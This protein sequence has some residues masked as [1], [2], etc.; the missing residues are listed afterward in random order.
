MTDAVGAQFET[1]ETSA[2]GSEAAVEALAGT[3]EAVGGQ[4]DTL[5]RGTATPIGLVATPT[6]ILTNGGEST[7]HPVLAATESSAPHVEAAVPAV[8]DRRATS[9]RRQVRSQR[10]RTR[11]SAP[12]RPPPSRCSGASPPLR[13]PSPRRRPRWRFL[14]VTSRHSRRRPSPS[15]LRRRQELVAAVVDVPGDP[16]F[17]DSA[18]TRLRG[19]GHWLRGHCSRPSG[20]RDADVRV[21]R[22]VSC[23]GRRHR[24]DGC[25]RRGRDRARSGRDLRPWPSCVLTG[26]LDAVHERAA[27]AVRRHCG[28]PALDRCGGLRRRQ[29]GRRRNPLDPRAVSSAS[30]ELA[31]RTVRRRLQGRGERI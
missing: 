3:V 8:T 21:R 13:I 19:A 7:L 26:R 1:A 6:E 24:H 4:I 28:N 10:R 22:V 2:A 17:G 31:C 23:A 14:R 25:E 27:A 18:G 5:T 15:H 11:R 9:C 12:E 16:V 30:A 20:V 29:P